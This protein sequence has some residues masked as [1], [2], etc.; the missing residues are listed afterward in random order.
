MRRMEPKDRILFIQILAQLMI[1]D[2][3]LNDKEREHLDRVMDELEMPEEE[4]REALA[5]VS[6]DSPVE[7]R[8]IQLSPGIG[9]RLVAAVAQAMYS[10]SRASDVEKDFLDRV[11]LLLG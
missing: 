1:I 10:D 11:T 6:V 8:V 9:D 4:R 2:G 3:V 7:E 5:R